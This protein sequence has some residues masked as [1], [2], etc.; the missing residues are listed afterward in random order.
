[1]GVG[2]VPLFANTPSGRAL[3]QF[4]SFALAANQRVLLRGLQEEKGKFWGG[5][6]GMAAIGALIYWVMNLKA[7]REVSDN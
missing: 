3:I 6:T 2:D 5:V 4:R 7:G 1:M